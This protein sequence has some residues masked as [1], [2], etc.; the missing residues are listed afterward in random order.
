MKSK[1]ITGKWFEIWSEYGFEDRL[2]VIARFF[3]KLYMLKLVFVALIALNAYIDYKCDYNLL[4]GHVGRAGEQRQLR[5]VPIIEDSGDNMVSTALFSVHNLSNYDCTFDKDCNSGKCLLTKDVYGNVT[6][7]HCTC[8]AGYT[9]D[10]SICS[11]RQLS[12]LATLLISIFLGELG[13]DLCFLSRGNCCYICCGIMKG[14][15]GGGFLIW[16]AVDIALIATGG[17]MDGNGKSL[18]TI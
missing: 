2:K 17:M 8:D 16:W 13:V 3:T 6:G 18:T 14:L 4:R 9:D 11:Y 1:Y 7:S 12:G 5:Y 15:T 10:S